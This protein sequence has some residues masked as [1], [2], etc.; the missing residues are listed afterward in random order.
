MR[1]CFGTTQRQSVHPSALSYCVQSKSI[2]SRAVLDSLH[3]GT[4]RTQKL[5]EPLL[6]SSP[7]PPFPCFHTPESP[8]TS[9]FFR[10]LASR[11]MTVSLPAVG[12]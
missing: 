11:T 3:Q 9:I 7:L 8:P 4:P 12:T 5:P 1:L 2:S 6:Q 10:F